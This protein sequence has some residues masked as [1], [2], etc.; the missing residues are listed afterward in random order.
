MVYLQY[1]GRSVHANRL[2]LIWP[3]TLFLVISLI[4]IPERAFAADCG[5]R[6]ECRVQA[7]EQQINDQETELKDLRED[8]ARAGLVLFLF[9][10]FCALWAQNVGR[11]AWLWF[12]MGLFF[13]VIVVLFLLYLNSRDKNNDPPSAA[14]A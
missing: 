8:A 11:N 12:F 1:T 13:N 5:E 4:L 9:A 2:L 3:L 7:L 14:A 10:A 6:L